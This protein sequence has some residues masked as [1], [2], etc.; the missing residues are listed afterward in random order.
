MAYNNYYTTP[1]YGLPQTNPFFNP[2]YFPNV[3][4]PQMQQPQQQAASQGNAAPQIQNGGFI[5]VQSE[6]EARQYPVAPGYSVTFID[7][8][9]S[10]CYTK[11]MGFSQFDKPK[12]EKFKLVKQEDETDTKTAEKTKEEPKVDLSAYA[13]KAELEPI[14]TELDALKNIIKIPTPVKEKEK[15]KDE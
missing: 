12:F 11:T 3:A 5:R 6:N 15:N 7:D 2:Q 9:A 8:S 13:T 10:Y 1:Q 14:I 4:P